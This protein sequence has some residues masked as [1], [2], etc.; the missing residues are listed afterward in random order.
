MKDRIEDKAKELY[1][2]ALP[3]ES[4]SDLSFDQAKKLEMKGYIDGYYRMAKHV[5]ASEIKARLEEQEKYALWS[6][7]RSSRIQEL[8]TQLSEL[9]KE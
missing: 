6:K 2:K 7:L 5:L 8:E 3:Q 9:E 1:D 4:W